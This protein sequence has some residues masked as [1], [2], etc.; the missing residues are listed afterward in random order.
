[1]HLTVAALTMHSAVRPLHTAILKTKFF[2]AYSKADVKLRPST[3]QFKEKQGVYEGL[4]YSVM[5][6]PELFWGGTQTGF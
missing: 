2:Q 5:A 1:M 6:G 4:A 3:Q